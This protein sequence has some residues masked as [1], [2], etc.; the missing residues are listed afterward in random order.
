MKNRVSRVKFVVSFCDEIP[1][2]VGDEAAASTVVDLGAV[3]EEVPVG[4]VFVRRI[5]EFCGDVEVFSMI[6]RAYGVV[7]RFAYCWEFVN[8]GYPLSS[9]CFRAEISDAVP[10]GAKSFPDLKKP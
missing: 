9:V 4:G 7:F 3:C 1:A 10:G 6:V 8:S 2:S 5:Y